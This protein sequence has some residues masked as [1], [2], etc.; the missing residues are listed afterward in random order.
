MKALQYITIFLATGLLMGCT[1]KTQLGEDNKGKERPSVGITVDEITTSEITSGVSV[2][3]KFTLAVSHD[4]GQ[5]AYAVLEGT[6]VAAPDAYS[7]LVG[8]VTGTVAAGTFFLKD[9]DAPTQYSFS[10]AIEEGEPYPDYTVFAAAI[11]PDGLT[12]EVASATVRGDEIP[13]PVPDFDVRRGGYNVNFVSDGGGIRI[14]SEHPGDVFLVALIPYEGVRGTDDADS[15]LWVLN[16]SWFNIAETLGMK[17]GS[18]VN[19]FLLGKLDRKNFTITFDRMIDPQSIVSDRTKWRI[20][21]SSPYETAISSNA[22]LYMMRGGG[23]NGTEPVVL[24]LDRTGKP[25]TLSS[26]GF[27]HLDENNTITAFYD[28]IGDDWASLVPIQ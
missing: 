27:A 2:S 23:R 5:Y 21:K 12:S 9:G 14:E 6:D 1:E 4:A 13:E 24:T 16:S 25:L 15:E 7:I 22:G 3:C 28:R 26:F 10:S 20:F 19:P 8:E 18:A 17:A 11:T